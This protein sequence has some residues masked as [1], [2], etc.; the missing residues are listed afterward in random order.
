MT[1]DTGRYQQNKQDC[2]DP[3]KT[4]SSC[5]SLG[6]QEKT[7]FSSKAAGRKAFGFLVFQLEKFIV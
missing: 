1:Q 7:T 4:G 3:E 6:L 5:K 2:P